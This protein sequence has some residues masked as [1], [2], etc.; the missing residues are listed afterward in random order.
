MA[1]EKLCILVDQFEELFRFAKETSREEAE[2]FVDLLTREIG[3]GK[4]SG[5]AHVVV[6]MRSEF[7]GECA[8]FDRFA[9]LIN[10]TQYLVPRIERDGL[11]RAI[12]RPAAL[13]GGAVAPGL[14]E[15]LIAEARGQSD[16]LPLI[17]HALMLMWN[18][19][20]ARTPEGET[21]L[22]DARLLDEAGG[23][24]ALLSGHADRVLAEAA[25]DEAR[26]RAAEQIFRALTDSNAESQAIRRPQTFGELIAVCGGEER[27]ADVRAILD[28]FRV[29]GVSF[30]TPYA[31]EPI[32]AKTVIDIGHESVIRCWGKIAAKREG[33][34]EKEFRDGQLWRSL[35]VQ[36]TRFERTNSDLLSQAATGETEQWLSERN[37]H[38]VKR[39]GGQW[40]LVGR[41]VQKS[42]HSR[43]EA[44]RKTERQ[45]SQQVIDLKEQ[46]VSTEFDLDGAKK[47]LRIALWAVA[48]AFIVAF[49]LGF[50]LPVDSLNHASFSNDASFSG[51]L[52]SADEK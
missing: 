7:L 43:D 40:D 49:V 32:E 25:P 22:L 4:E 14:A 44:L 10:R 8:R 20:T 12:T 15:R 19:A 2:V 6:T 21:I 23:L 29:E 38:W 28:A 3:E 30:L 39:Y 36:A 48:I 46:L 24:A 18:E 31:P 27:E 1:G 50:S 17:Q 34:L 41:L 33:W 52:I 26:L 45:R 51:R 42:I 37:V 9:E 35:V 16:E 5:A 47:Q 13:Y 11:E